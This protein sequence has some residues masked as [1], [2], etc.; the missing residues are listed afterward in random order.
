M[1]STYER[2]ALSGKSDVDHVVAP[3]WTFTLT[4]PNPRRRPT[5]STISSA[6]SGGSV[7]KTQ[8]AFPDVSHRVA[9]NASVSSTALPASRTWDKP[10]GFDHVFVVSG[11]CL[12]PA[13]RFPSRL[14]R[15]QNDERTEL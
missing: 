2:A 4:E 14:D 8:V 9:E 7:T 12:G 3:I 11:E 15:E 10:G 1:G 13:R 5:V 6:S